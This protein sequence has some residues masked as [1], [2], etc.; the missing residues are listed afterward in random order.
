MDH[1]NESLAIFTASYR[2]EVCGEGKDLLS[3][4]QANFN[5]VGEIYCC[6]WFLNFVLTERVEYNGEGEYSCKFLDIHTIHI[7][8]VV[9]KTSNEMVEVHGQK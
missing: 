7:T 6:C 8:N 5:T 4:P 9:H 2:M 3:I 1:P